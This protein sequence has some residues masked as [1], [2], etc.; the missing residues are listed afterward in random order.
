[1]RKWLPAHYGI[2]GAILIVITVIAYLSFNNVAKTI[3]I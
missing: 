3:I 2:L 1:M